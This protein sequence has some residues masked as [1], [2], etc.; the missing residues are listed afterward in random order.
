MSKTVAVAEIEA[1]IT[2]LVD[3]V[4]RT[5][6]EIVITKDGEPVVR[7]VPANGRKRMTLEELRNSVTFIGDIMEPVEEWDM[8]K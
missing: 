5:Q 1:N 8:T 4:A 7:L 2:A 3:E 6:E